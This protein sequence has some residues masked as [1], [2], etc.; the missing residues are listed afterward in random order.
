MLMEKHF[1]ND[2]H[3]DVLFAVSESG[4]TNSFLSL[5]WLRC[6]ISRLA[7]DGKDVIACSFLTVMGVI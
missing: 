6:L 4:Y 2:I 1:D 5:D 3:D 7:H